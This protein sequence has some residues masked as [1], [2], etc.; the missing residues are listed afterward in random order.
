MVR[1]RLPILLVQFWV[2]DLAPIR[3]ALTAAGIDARLVRVD[4]EPALHAALSWDRYA[5]VIYDPETPSLSRATVEELVRTSR[6]DLPLILVD[7]LAT[8]GARVL[9][10]LRARQN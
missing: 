10:A 1:A 8:L 9:A 7:D 2:R 3:T 4:I 5:A 6:A